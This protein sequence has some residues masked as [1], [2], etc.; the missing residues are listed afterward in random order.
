MGRM[1]AGLILAVALLA[2]GGSA[3]AGFLIDSATALA[4]VRAGGIILLDVRSPGE[5]R[6]TG[7]P[8]G[9]K[10]VTIHDPNGM[11]GFVAAVSRIVG[12]RK[13]Q[14]IALICARGG[15]SSRAMDVLRAAGFSNLS[16][17]REGMLGNATD[18]P[19]WLG[20][21]LPVEKFR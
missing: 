9:A 16:N 18:G 6:R 3:N 4:G 1:M 2:S 15:R 20:R 12:G 10:T 17:L 14:P 11:A 19:G 7:V 8:L 5:W 13:D 21:K